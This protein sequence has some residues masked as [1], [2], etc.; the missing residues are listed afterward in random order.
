M[1]IADRIR[2]PW[3]ARCANRLR[4]AVL[5]WAAALL[6]GSAAAHA[7]EAGY[8]LLQ[9][10]MLPSVS[11]WDY[12]SIDPARRA[13]YVSNNSG[14]LVI[15]VDSMREVGTVPSPPAWRGIG[16]VHGVAFAGD[17]GRGFISRELPPSITTFDL[18]S[19]AVLR[20]TPTDP[21]TDAIVY[22][23]ATRRVFTFNGKRHGVH[24][25]TAMDAVTGRALANIPLP[26]VPEFAAADG[27]GNVYVNIASSSELGRIDSRSLRL[28]SVWKMAPCRDPSALAIDPAHRRL[29]AACANRIMV[30]LSAD[31]GRVLASV[32]TG[33]G[34]DAA[35]FDQSTGDVFAS[36]GA[37]T[38]TVAREA[39]PR[40]LELL[41]QVQTEPGARTMAL[42]AKTHRV[43]LLSAKFAAAP[44]RP[45]GD[46]PHGYPRAIAGTARLL[47]YGP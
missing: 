16:L 20:S 46:N 2:S 42:D 9:R 7:A 14:I 43:F 12:L 26:G 23:P 10:V 1:R 8:H 25:A 28:A 47:V 29:F 37:G 18:A 41:Q 44:E 4:V 11:G 24:D 21:G 19:L 15:D 13:L 36:N 6:S 3:R 33:A 39:D 27:R 22:D 32:P 38:L 31:T 40:R 45:T 5:L 30:M 34:T 17:L 35:V